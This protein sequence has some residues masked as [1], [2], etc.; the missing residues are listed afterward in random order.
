M[1]HIGGIIIA[2]YWMLVNGATIVMFDR[3]DPDV[4]LNAIRAYK[5]PK[6]GPIR[7]ACITIV[8]LSLGHD[9]I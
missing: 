7:L 5:V 3:Y 6:T 1:F 4:Y 9:T 2:G 8:P